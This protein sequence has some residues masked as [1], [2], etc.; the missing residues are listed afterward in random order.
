M[1]KRNGIRLNDVKV[2]SH[3]DYHFQ[4][5]RRIK[6]AHRYYSEWLWETNSTQ[7]HHA[8]QIARRVAKEN[9]G[10]YVGLEHSIR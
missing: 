8:I 10:R 7:K 5:F 4:I 3:A 9:R 2:V 6:F 1:A